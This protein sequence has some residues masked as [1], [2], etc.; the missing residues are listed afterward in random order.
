MIDLNFSKTP[1]IKHGSQ[2]KKEKLAS[3]QAPMKLNCISTVSSCSVV[4]VVSWSNSSGEYK[5]RIPLIP[6]GRQEP[7]ERDARGS[8]GDAQGDPGSR[9]PSRGE[10]GNRNR[11]AATTPNS[12]GQ[13]AL[14]ATT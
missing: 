11:A 3:R 13:F 6:A 7:G 5:K 9:G 12:L 2:K 4:C 14:A 1:V 10:T 8:G